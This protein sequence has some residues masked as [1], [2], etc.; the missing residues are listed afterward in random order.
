MLIKNKNRGAGVS[1]A[2]LFSNSRTCIK[3]KASKNQANQTAGHVNASRSA[4]FIPSGLLTATVTILV[5]L[6][7]SSFLSIASRSIIRNGSEII[8]LKF[9]I[10]N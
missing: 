10:S 2:L 5:S 1:P 7:F 3:P 8:D 9:E 6:D 4:F